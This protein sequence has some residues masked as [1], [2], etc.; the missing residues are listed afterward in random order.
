VPRHASGGA[1]RCRPPSAESLSVEPRYKP[2]AAVAAVSRDDDSRAAG[3]APQQ[4]VSVRLGQR[5]CD[6][7]V[8]HRDHLHP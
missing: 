5:L 4:I 1:D 7:R 8:S 2:A 6:V 3:G